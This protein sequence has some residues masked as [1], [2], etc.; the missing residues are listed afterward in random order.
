MIIAGGMLFNIFEVGRF[1]SES[2]VKAKYNVMSSSISLVATS[3]FKLFLIFLEADL[4]WFA[5]AYSFEIILKSIGFIVFYQI[6]NKDVFKW[7]FNTNIAKKLLR[8][9]WPFILV[10]IMGTLYMRMDQ[11]MLK[12]ML[13]LE[14]VGIYSAALR[15]SEIWYFIPV[16]IT[17]S[18]FP[19]I[20]V[21]K[22][23]NEEFYYKRLK[24]L[25][26]LLVFIAIIII[27][28]ITIFSNFLISLIYGSNYLGSS[29]VLK[30]HVWSCFFVFTGNILGKWHIV[31]NKQKILLFRT[32]F[33]VVSNVILNLILIPRFEAV[34]AAYA[35]L[36]SFFIVGHLS[37]FLFK[38]MRKI[39]IIQLRAVFF[40]DTI[41]Y[42]YN[43]LK[44]YRNV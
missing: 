37:G 19:A 34:G 13:D 26:N 31:E 28:P 36:F 44:N 39:M 18:L 3:V 1:H 6:I 16:A 8:D 38:D 43:Y 30:I 22:K 29:L 2:Q 7:K 12:E 14:A 9:S 4:I 33:G 10:G 25:F 23:D 20:I 11:L 32:L 27:L 24:Q 41:I 5:I 42:I 21:A 17:G 40:I 15:L 35:S